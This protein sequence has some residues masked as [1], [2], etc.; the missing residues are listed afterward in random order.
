MTSTELTTRA[1]ERVE[2]INKM[3]QRIEE[4]L[5]NSDIMLN[6]EL[7]RRKAFNDKRLAHQI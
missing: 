7:S 3:A 6:C 5:K 2:Q 4:K 1:T